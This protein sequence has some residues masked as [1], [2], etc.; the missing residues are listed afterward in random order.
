[1][2][3]CFIYGSVFDSW[4]I[5]DMNGF[6]TLSLST[7][8]VFNGLSG[9]GIVGI[10]LPILYKFLCFYYFADLTG[11]SFSSIWLRFYLSW[12]NR[13]WLKALLKLKEVSLLTEFLDRIDTFKSF[14]T[15]FKFCMFYILSFSFVLVE[16]TSI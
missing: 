6:S 15:W 14:W 13:F 9:S 5:T 7:P 4:F 8:G 3:Y 1:M 12:K 16:F 2:I 11:L 10:D